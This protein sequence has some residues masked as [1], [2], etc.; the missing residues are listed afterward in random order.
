MQYYDFI[1]LENL[2]INE[3]TQLYLVKTGEKYTIRAIS[4]GLEQLPSE[5][6]LR[7]DGYWI[8]DSQ[9]FFEN[10]QDNQFQEFFVKK[11]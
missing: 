9:R 11:S 5:P 4:S 7:A 3:E 2:T 1:L 6:E 8:I 10:L